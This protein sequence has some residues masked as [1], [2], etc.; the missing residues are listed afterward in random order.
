MLTDLQGVVVHFRG[1]GL[2]LRNLAPTV[3]EMLYL[4]ERKATAVG[5]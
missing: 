2:C 4:S 1:P 3:L 5:A